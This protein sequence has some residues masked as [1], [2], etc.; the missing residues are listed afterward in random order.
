MGSKPQL[1]IRMGSHAEKEYVVKLNHKVFDGIIVGANV[2]EATSG[3][4]ASLLGKKLKLPF[5]IDPMT[6]VFGCDLD[7]I[8]S[9]QKRKGKTVVDYKRSYRSLAAKLGAVFKGALDQNDP[10]TSSGF[11]RSQVKKTCQSVVDYQLNCIRQE[12][13]A[14]EEY[15]EYSEVIPLPTGVF[16]PYFYI[17]GDNKDDFDLFLRLTTATVQLQVEVPVHAVLCANSE[18]LND[19]AFVDEVLEKLPLTGAKGIWLWFS[20]FDEWESNADMLLNFRNLVE[21]L[22]HSGLQVFNRHGGFFSILLHKYGMTGLSHGVG[23][24]EK[25]DVLQIKGPPNAPIVNYYVPA[26]HKRFGIPDIEWCFDNLNVRTVASFHTNICG[27]VICKGV[28][29]NSL[30]DFSE[31]GENHKATPESSRMTQTPAAAKRCR[32]HFLMNRL[33]EKNHVAKHDINSLL[34]N[35][36]ANRNSWKKNAGVVDFHYLN[37]WIDALS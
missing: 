29:R 16:S 7:G 26:L 18:L 4:T 23:Y 10:I 24:G 20:K 31:F 9:E 12:F 32:Y 11:P 5:Y 35:L 34:A 3:A 17:H 30:D 1:I 8:R 15:S 37:R 6:Y 36:K 19:S 14:D 28:V 2:F 21:G 33:D 13:S 22:S 25:K 27:C